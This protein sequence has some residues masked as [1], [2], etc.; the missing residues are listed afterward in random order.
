MKQIIN[1]SG[2]KDSTA[3]IHLMIERGEQ[4]DEIIF[5]DG[6]WE[7]PEMYEHIDRVERKTGLKITRLKPAHDFNY[8]FQQHEYWSRKY[9]AR[10]GYGWPGVK[11][12]WCTRLK[13]DTIGRYLKK[14]EKGEVIQCIGF[15]VGEEARAA[16]K[17]VQDGAYR[18][19]LIEYDYDEL[20]CKKYCYRLGYKFGGLY[21]YFDRVS[22]WCCPL[23]SMKELFLKKRHFPERWDLLR[24]MDRKVKEVRAA[25]GQIPPPRYKIAYELE[26]IDARI[27]GNKLYE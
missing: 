24:E 26:E 4:I 21:E 18:F 17:R 19:P 22:C 23:Q 3:M 2:G 27:P 9:G 10:T 13:V 8:Y 1:F 7:W 12:R 25:A 20:E 16:R 5:F 14:Y 15:A 11:L 6:G